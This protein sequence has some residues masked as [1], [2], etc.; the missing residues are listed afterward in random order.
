MKKIF[1]LTILYLL[2]FTGLALAETAI[3]RIAIAPQIVE[4]EPIDSDMLFKAGSERL[5]CFTE[6]VTDQAPTNIVHVWMY[7]GKVMAEVPLKVG[8]QR[9]RTYSSKK[10]IKAWHG[11][12]K[13]EVYSEE[14]ALL[15]TAEFVVLE[16]DECECE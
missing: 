12:W 10:M 14:G 1:L 6:V 16:N 9:W 8:S 13:V 3:Q 11:E 2:S 5:Y 15:K 7:R 4:R